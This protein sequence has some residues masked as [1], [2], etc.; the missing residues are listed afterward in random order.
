MSSAATATGSARWTTRRRHGSAP[1]SASAATTGTST[2]PL[3][4]VS[5]ARPAGRGVRAGLPAAAG[6]V[7][8]GVAA[9]GGQRVRD[10]EVRRVVGGGPVA[11]RGDDAR[12]AHG[13]REEADERRA[14]GAP[15]AAGRR[16]KARTP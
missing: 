7:V 8:A 12:H 4:R 15:A 16:S 13:Q 2:S 1:G 11:G 3:V 5:A 14:H 10:G 9:E 6:G